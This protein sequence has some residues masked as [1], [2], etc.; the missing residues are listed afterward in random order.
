LQKCCFNIDSIK[1]KIKI[2]VWDKEAEIEKLKNSSNKGHRQLAETLELY[3]YQD[4]EAYNFDLLKRLYLIE[5]NHKIIGCTSPSTL[6]F[7]TANDLS[8]AQIKLTKNDVTFD[9]EYTPLYERDSEFQKYFYLLFKANPTLSQRLTVVNEYLE[10][11]L[12]I[13]DTGKSQVV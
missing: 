12:K 11:N 7:A 2:I 9:D 4:K 13:L 8:H 1:D 6:F 5:Y 3:L 10:K